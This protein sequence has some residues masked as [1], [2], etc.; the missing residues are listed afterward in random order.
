MSLFG[1][2]NKLHLDILCTS[3]PFPVEF[4]LGI[5]HRPELVGSKPD[6]H[7]NLHTPF[8][9]GPNV[10]G[11][12]IQCIRIQYHGEQWQGIHIQMSF[13]FYCRGIFRALDDLMKKVWPVSAPPP[14]ARIFQ[15]WN[16]TH[17]P[18][19]IRSTVQNSC[20]NGFFLD[21]H[22]KFHQLPRVFSQDMA[23]I[24]KS[25]YSEPLHLCTPHTF[26][27]DH[28]KTLANHMEHSQTHQNKDDFQD[29]R[30]CCFLSYRFVHW[31]MEHIPSK[32]R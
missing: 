5:S 22:S 16:C 21:I 15:Q 4:I 13:G 31:G 9:L 26:Y 3:R 12:S 30:K 24:S 18:L 14:P 7:H 29:T 27:F 25:S 19:H 6:H 8:L 20:H 10:M 28:P 32:F 1:S 23:D 17:Y 11:W 2:R